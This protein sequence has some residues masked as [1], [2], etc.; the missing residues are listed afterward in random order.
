LDA[1][2]ASFDDK[3]TGE[4]GQKKIAIVVDGDQNQSSHSSQR[5]PDGRWAACPNSC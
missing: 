5:T 2:Q 1:I 3:W 4:T